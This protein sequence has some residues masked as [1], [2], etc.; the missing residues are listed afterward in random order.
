MRKIVLV[1]LACV[2]L[3]PLTS[4]RAADDLTDAAVII[5]AK[6]ETV[7]KW[8]FPPRF[9]VVHDRPVDRDAF[10]ETTDFIRRATG[11]NVPAPEYID[12]SGDRLGDRFYTASR[13]KPRRIE[14]GQMTTDLLI[15]GREDLMLSANVFVFVVSP[16]LASHFMVLTA[17]GRSSTALPRA[18][19]E[20][21]GPCYF[22]VLSNHES[23]Q[24][25]TI[26]IAPG[27]E[28]EFTRACIYEEMVQAM[29]LVNDAHDSP[30]FTFDNLAPAKPRDY[31]QR[32][33]SAL[34]HPSVET[35]DAVDKVLGIY[36]Q[37]Q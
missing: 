6:A 33:L 31:D 30:F 17:W 23:I 20:G 11:L 25:G 1:F 13:Y 7:K 24:F 10:D 14:A 12:L 28:S 27:M 3:L 36:A 26:L 22:N 5:N 9:V 8:R 34:Y 19:A 35:G 16:P 18:Y 29:G 15:A 37:P 32:L 21:T 4:A 2:L